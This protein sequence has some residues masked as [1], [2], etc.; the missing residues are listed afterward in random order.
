MKRI[1]VIVL[2]AIILASMSVFAGDAQKG[3]SGKALGGGAGGNT[4]SNAGPAVD[5]TCNLAQAGGALL[6]C[7]LQ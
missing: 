1:M 7:I 5:E 6:P 2:V 4:G 3:S